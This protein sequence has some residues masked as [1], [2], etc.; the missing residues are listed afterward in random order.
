MKIYSDVLFSSLTVFFRFGTNKRNEKWYFLLMIIIMLA[1]NNIGDEHLYHNRIVTEKRVTLLAL[2]IFNIPSN[3]L[4]L[5]KLFLGIRSTVFF[6]CRFNFPATREFYF[7]T[8]LYNIINSAA[9]VLF[10]I[11][12]LRTLKLGKPSLVMTQYI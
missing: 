3:I 11:F 4:P 1:G 5:Q 6:L 10:L 12:S 9:G 7:L 2:P 8:I